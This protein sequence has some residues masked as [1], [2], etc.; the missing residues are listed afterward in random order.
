[1]AQDEYDSPWKNGLVRYLLRFFEF[2]FPEIYEDVEWNTNWKF[3]DGV[4]QAVAPSKSQN[5][6]AGKRVVDALVELERRSGERGAVLVHI[7]VQAQRVKSFEKR[8]LLS[9]TCIL[10]RYEKPVCSLAVLADR[11][12]AWRPQSYRRSLWGNELEF[13]F[14]ISKLL[15]FQ[16]QIGQLERSNNP[17]CILTAATLHQQSTRPDSV[18]RYAIKTRMVRGLFRLGLGKDDI[19]EF[20]R[21]IDWNLKLS[22]E[23]EIKFDEDL[24]RMGEETGMP[25]M[26]GFER[27]AIERGV[28][29]GRIEGRA[30][31]RAEGQ[32]ALREVVHEILQ[33]RFGNISTDMI[34]QLEA[35]DSL[36]RLRVLGRMAATVEN[37]GAF[38]KKLESTKQEPGD[39]V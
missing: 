33:S 23:L 15:D 28:E 24:R 18:E 4:L 25:Y 22:P 16:E 8:M 14:P 7:E 3:L 31:G 2:F 20:F 36:E 35:I 17:F 9:H 10:E 34:K 30:E 1:M 5:S 27:R 39:E 26:S 29:K 13:K 37:L 38:L 21:L 6:R 32:C 12:Q 19:E 11:S